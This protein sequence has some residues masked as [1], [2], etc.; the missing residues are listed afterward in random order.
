MEI[1]RLDGTNT[2][3]A[4]LRVAEVLRSGGLVIYPTDTVYGIAVDVDNDAALARF[5]ALKGRDEYKRTSLLVES[6]EAMERY[7][8][9][10]KVA[11]ELAMR[12]L[13][14]ALTLVLP[15][16]DTIRE[17]LQLEG[18]I[19]LRVPNHPFCIALA[20]AFGA[21]LTATS[22]NKSGMPTTSS[23]AD[24]QEQFKRETSDIDLIIDGGALPP[25]MASTLVSCVTDVPVVLREGAMTRE[26]LG[27]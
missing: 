5:R 10:N 18:T 2:D 13:P 20:R 12:F 9:M 22:A 15:V 27:F 3:A 24:I 6:V 14:G 17:T 25:C 8:Y 19:A 21:P 26:E 7:G 1:I 23:L 16:K 11:R 4:A